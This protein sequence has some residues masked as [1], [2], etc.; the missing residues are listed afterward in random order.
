MFFLQEKKS[1]SPVFSSDRNVTFEGFVF[2]EYTQ[3]A[4]SFV[5]FSH[6]CFAAHKK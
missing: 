4:P 1:V 6:F 5:D 2:L 3:K